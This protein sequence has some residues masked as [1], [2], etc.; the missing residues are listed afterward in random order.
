MTEPQ[1][2]LPEAEIHNKERLSIIWLVPLVALAIGL[3]LLYQSLISA[4]TLIEVQ[5]QSGEGLAAGKTELRYQGVVIGHIQEIDL[6]PDRQSVIALIAV[7]RTAADLLRGGSQFWRVKPKISLQG[8][9]GL[10]T[11]LSGQ[12]ISFFPGEG[13]PQLKFEALAAP[14]PGIQGKQSL[15]IRL[16]ASTLGSIQEG[17]PV[18]YRDITVGRVQRYELDAAIDRVNIFVGIDEPYRELIRD[19][20]H[21]WNN[22]GIQLEGGLSGLKL[23]TRSLAAMLM[24]GISFEIPDGEKPGN[25][26]KPNQLFALYEDFETANTGITV[27]VSFD[28]ADGIEAGA[29]SVQYRGLKVGSVSKLKFEDSLSE[30]IAEIRLPREAEQVLNENSRFWLVKPQLSLSGVSGLETLL[31]G[32]YIELDPGK[33]KKRQFQFKAIPE[34]PPFDKNLPG[35]HIRLSSDQLADLSRGAPVYYRRIPVGLVQGY[36]LAKD[37]KAVLIDLQIEQKYASLIS[38]ESRFWKL[39]ALTAQGSLDGL[40]LNLAPLRTL[41]AGGIEFDNIETKQSKQP[42][43]PDHRFTLYSD[44]DSAL[45][46]GYKL[47]IL[48]LDAPGIKPG[49]LIRHRGIDIG[50]VRSVH[51]DL[52]SNRVITTALIAPSMAEQMTSASHFWVVGPELGLTGSQNLETL[53]SGSYIAFHPG[54]GSQ[55]RQIVGHEK[56]PNLIYDTDGLHLILESERLGSISQNAPVYYRQIEVGKVRGYELAPTADHVLIHLSIEP[57][58][59]PLIHDKTKFWNSSGIDFSFKLLSGAK[60]ES[61]SLKT[62][63][64]GGISFATPQEPEDQG[65]P[66]APGSQFALHAKPETAWLEWRPKIFLNR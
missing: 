60:L 4:D 16:Q 55:S 9:S 36:Q 17:S 39:S 48:F 42:L 37:S 11:L 14:P 45:R 54:P 52:H 18:N 59:A 58:Y 22:S 43:S 35:L 34:P 27:N 56:A 13:E 29:T 53:I 12:Y 2:P 7:R 32:N 20:T 26:A 64:A 31:R 33:G 47:E 10:D 1:A 51:F 30:V 44:R 19:N 65:Q 38:P 66:A 57:R 21:F 15:I 6:S 61:E 49:S 8:I 46:R 3:W 25:A 24:G 63:L 40:K 50:E 23:R 62:L 28:S 41:L 5:F